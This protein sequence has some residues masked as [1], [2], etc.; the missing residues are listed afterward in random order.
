MPVA[1]HYVLSVPAEVSSRTLT[2]N[3][4]IHSAEAIIIGTKY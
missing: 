3:T 1:R 2:M 4:F